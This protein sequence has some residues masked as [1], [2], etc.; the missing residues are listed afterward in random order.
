MAKRPPKIVIV[1]RPNVGK[2]TLFRHLTRKPVIVSPIPGTTRDRITALW[3]IDD[4][5]VELTDMGGWAYKG[6]DLI[7]HIVEQIE[8]ALK[9]VD[10]VL[11]MVDAKTGLTPDDEALAHRLRMLKRPV[12]LI[13]NKIDKEKEEPLVYEFLRVG[14][15]N[16]IPISS[17]GRRN[18][19][20]L[21]KSV[22]SIV[23]SLPT[24]V[25]IESDIKV[26]IVGKPNVGKSAILNAI[27]GE[28]RVVVDSI[29]GTTRDT[30]DTH[31]RWF[32]RSITLIDTA[33]LRRQSKVRRGDI[34]ERASVKRAVEAIERADICLLIL[35][36]VSDISNQD[37]AIAGFTKEVGK[38]CIICVNKVDLIEMSTKMRY[39]IEKT[40]REQ[41]RFIP[42]TPII[43]TSAVKRKNIGEILQTIIKVHNNWTK[44]VSTSNINR[45]EIPPITIKGKESK[46]YYITQVD[47][48]PPKFVIM[49]NIAKKPHFSFER[50]IEN[51]I[52]ENFDFEG[53]PIILEFR[54]RR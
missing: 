4:G 20:E 32:G 18:I 14:F 30:I 27:V 48:C 26:T 44:R 49:T 13:V 25:D 43:I 34:L 46:V 53:T 29:P 6:D 41:F 22:K 10:I 31:L 23:G 16:I 54:E 7:K 36:A 1:G 33:G 3:K 40:I 21:K 19:N 51:R 35:D 42:Y 28:E 9:Y 15:D 8:I 39:K 50:Y 45:L 52:R 11:F 47:T 5:F 17:K 37:K 38:G 2:S 12:I 24:K